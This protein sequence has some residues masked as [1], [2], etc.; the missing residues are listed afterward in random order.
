[1]SNSDKALTRAELELTQRL[2]THFPSGV[3][4]PEV[5][6]QWNGCPANVITERLVSAFGRGPETAIPAVPPVLSGK[7]LTDLG[8]LEFWLEMWQYLGWEINPSGLAVPALCGDFNWL[9]VVPQGITTNKAYDINSKLFWCWR[10]MDDLEGDS[11][12]DRDA[13][14]G[15]YVIRVRD[16]IE[17]ADEFRQQSEREHQEKRNQPIT[18]TERQILE[19]AVFLATGQHLDVRLGTSCAGTRY[20]GTFGIFYVPDC[21]WKTNKFRVFWHRID[22]GG[23]RLRGR[24]I[25]SN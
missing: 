4:Q 10:E 1:M 17:S 20:P 13:S 24:R 6:Q 8:K 15:P 25:I 16:H 3:I 21:D 18:L 9:I 23:Y 12:N 14:K 7:S 2:Q 22:G 19:T 5:I 11:K